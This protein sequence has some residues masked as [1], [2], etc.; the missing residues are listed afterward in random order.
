MRGGGHQIACSPQE[1]MQGQRHRASGEVVG[2]KVAGSLSVRPRENETGEGRAGSGGTL[3]S[4][5]GRTVDRRGVESDSYFRRKT[6]LK[7]GEQFRAD[8]TSDTENASEAVTIKLAG[9]DILGRLCPHLSTL[10]FL[11]EGKASW[12]KGLAGNS[13]VHLIVFVLLVSNGF[14]LQSPSCEHSPL[15]KA[16]L[17]NWEAT[18]IWGLS[19][20]A[21]SPLL[22]Q[23][24]H[25]GAP[26]IPRGGY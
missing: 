17:Q 3:R 21:C 10:G 12:R 18:D 7:C 9:N 14:V 22:G 4:L 16:S 5:H 6:W 25:T 11:S 19:R 15:V 24:P 13:F 26:T 23:L 20:S 8:K 2:I 1:P